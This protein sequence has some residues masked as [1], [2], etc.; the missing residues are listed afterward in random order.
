[1]PRNYHRD[2]V[3]RAYAKYNKE[4]LVATVRRIKAKQLTVSTAAKQTRISYG[5]MWNAVHD[6]HRGSTGGQTRL[7]PE[8]ELAVV[9]AIATTM[10]KWNMPLTSF[11][12][13]CLVKGYS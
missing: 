8:S 2:P 12:I 11:D 10:T 13:K 1:M 4:D 5:T 6:K 7:S 9:D 3:S